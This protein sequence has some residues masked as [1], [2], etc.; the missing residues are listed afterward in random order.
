MAGKF[1]SMIWQLL[2]RQ[3]AI[4]FNFFAQKAAMIGGLPAAIRR[5]QLIEGFFALKSSLH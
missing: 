3:L 1:C 5:M 4:A 2:P